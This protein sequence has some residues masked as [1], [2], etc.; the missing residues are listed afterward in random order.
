MWTL[1]SDDE[2][3][4]VFIVAGVARW[5]QRASEMDQKR[6]RVLDQ[7]GLKIEVMVV[8]GCKGELKC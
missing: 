6:Q 4:V 3:K 1:L 7:R 8:G 2:M 5:S